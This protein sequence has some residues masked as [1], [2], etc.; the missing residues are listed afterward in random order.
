MNVITMQ[1]ED[2]M[3]FSIYRIKGRIHA[4]LTADEKDWVR[5]GSPGGAIGCFIRWDGG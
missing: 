4:S 2:E 3:V 1:R 5:R